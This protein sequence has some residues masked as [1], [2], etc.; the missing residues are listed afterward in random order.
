MLLR[1]GRS[2]LVAI[3][4]KGGAFFRLKKG[5]KSKL[6]GGDSE[7]VIYLLGGKHMAQGACH[8]DIEYIAKGVPAF[9]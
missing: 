4:L 6:S 2:I 5:G 7:S 3:Q 8:V 1:G 9:S